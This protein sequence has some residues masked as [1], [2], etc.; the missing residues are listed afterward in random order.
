LACLAK[1]MEFYEYFALM[2]RRG[3]VALALFVAVLANSPAA[4]AMGM[5]ND[6]ACKG[7]ISAIELGSLD[8]QDNEGLLESDLLEHACNY[9]H[10]LGLG[11][12]SDY[13]LASDVKSMQRYFT[14]HSAWSGSEP[15][16]NPEPPSA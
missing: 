8:E 13:L 7:V 10:Q 1:R 4:V 5:P 3:F 2:F 16:P 12:A 11:A 6:A 15:A 14:C 9:S